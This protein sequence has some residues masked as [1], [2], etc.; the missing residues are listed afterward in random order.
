M[1]GLRRTGRDPDTDAIVV[2]KVADW[3]GAHFCLCQSCTAQ[4]LPPAR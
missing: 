4:D 3:L 2:L 1:R